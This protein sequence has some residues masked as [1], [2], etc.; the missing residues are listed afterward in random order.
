MKKPLPMPKIPRRRLR[1]GFVVA[2]LLSV[3]SVL[4]VFAMG[5]WM[6]WPFLAQPLERVLSSGLERKV[7][8]GTDQNAGAP[9]F[10]VRFL[11]G[12]RLTAPQLEIGAPAWSQAPHTLLA[13]DVQ[14][15]LRYVDVWRAY[16][17]QPIRI[18]SLQA[19]SLDGNLER[20]KDGRA[21]WQ[22]RLEPTPPD[23]PAKPLRLPLFGRLLVDGGELRLH[24][25]V[26]ATEVKASVS[27]APAA[28][29]SSPLG[30]AAVASTLK[31][32]ADGRYR[33][34]PLK[35]LLTSTAL[36]P[37][38]EAEDVHSLP[39]ELALDATVGRTQLWFKGSA[40]DVLQPDAFAGKF[41]LKGPS[42][43]AVGDPVGVTLPTTAAFRTEGSLA[44][45]G[46]TWNVVVDDATV[47][48][49]RLKGAF[50]YEA[51][52][53]IPL[54]SGRLGGT[55]LLLAD[56]GP[57]VGTTPAVTAAEAEPLVPKAR[58][59][60]KVL[61]DR[62]FDLPALRAMDANV[63][64]D[65]GEVDMN[66]R[67]LEPLQPLRGHLQLVGG[68]LTL[69]DVLARTAQG[70]LRGDLALDGRGT[71]ALWNADVRW[72]GV[73]L[74]RWIQQTR[75]KGL[76]PYVAGKLQGRATLTGQG[77][78]TAEIL[79]SLKG[80][81]RTELRDGAVSHLGVELA[82]I[83]LAES[84]GVLIKGD[85]A[86]PVQ[87]AVADL[88]VDSGLF[89]PRAMV[90]DTSDSAVWVS[91]SLSLAT[92]VLDLHAVVVPKDFSPLTLRTPVRIRG[93]F[94]QP[95][96]SLDKGPLGAKVATAVLL[97]LV[98]PLAAVIPFIDLGDSAEA[99][100]DAAGCRGLK[101]RAAAAAAKQRPK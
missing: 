53:P 80:Q 40:K 85:D 46:S 91:G 5:E 38:T 83:D 17:G 100:R 90:V 22:F 4:A 7:R 95:E 96:V 98:N 92:E 29:A 28:A 97:A 11:G 63:V 2:A 87:C 21:S 75:A 42:L 50:T 41:S 76:P 89:R 74:E 52:R 31:L 77:R 13:Q 37:S 15:Q 72:D 73:R 84:L 32:Q 6:G 61:P 23:T 65:I 44:K 48:A 60:G 9:G 34:M 64:I 8:L 66:T 1:R 54:L 49:S 57:V 88:T 58:S 47:G 27:L 68:V 99:Q 19:S 70:Q 43:A 26:L 12:I 59:K 51:G 62:P 79:A 86:L 16:R 78:S 14:L 25:A 10:R 30:S 56:L 94:S 18:Q 33:D 39:A 101:Q 71:K 69:R 24:D 81:L 3:L 67:L 20:L 82:G 36:L 93:T 35:I 55:R 45:Q